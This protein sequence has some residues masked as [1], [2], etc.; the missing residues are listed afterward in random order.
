[1]AALSTSDNGCAERLRSSQHR[2]AAGNCG[3][4]VSGAHLQHKES[5]KVGST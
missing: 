2:F 4:D 1:M 3:S 5:Y